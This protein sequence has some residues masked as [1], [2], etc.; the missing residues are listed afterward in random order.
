M[1]FPALFLVA[2]LSAPPEPTPHPFAMRALIPL[3][4]GAAL[5]V[6]GGVFLGV[7]VGQTKAAEALEPEPRDALLFTATSNRVGGVMLLTA[8]VLVS[9]IAGFLFWFIP[10]PRVSV[11]LMPIAGG[12]LFSF[13]WQ[14]P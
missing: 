2:L 10:P 11:G 14:V 13:G 4:I 12:A 3:S 9:A 6:G 8:G 1:T 5:L 7:S